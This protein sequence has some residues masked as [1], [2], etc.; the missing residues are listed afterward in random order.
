[1]PEMKK[2]KAFELLVD[3]RLRQRTA[4]ESTESSRQT[5]E[6]KECVTIERELI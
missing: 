2:E 5:K 6:R 1:M 4:V 3:D